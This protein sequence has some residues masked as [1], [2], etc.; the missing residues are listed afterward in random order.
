MR[1]ECYWNNTGKY[2][3]ES[4]RLN[5]LMPLAGNCET[6][7]GEL[8]RA[9]SKVYYDFNNNGMGNNTSGAINFLNAKGAICSDTYETIHPWTRGRVYNGRYDG[10]SLCV[11]MESMI[12]E[13]IEFILANPEL[14]KT[15]NTEDMFQYEDDEMKFCHGCDEE[16]DDDHWGSLCDCCEEEEEREYNTCHECGN[17]TRYDPC[18]CDEA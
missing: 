11:A 13:T 15:E 14:E 12:N 18:E 17:D 9:Y 10:D 2:E 3:E 6:V 1:K 8:V 7:A 16:L 4:N 5:E